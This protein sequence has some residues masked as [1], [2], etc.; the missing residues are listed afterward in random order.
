M[1]L[2]KVGTGQ[3]QEVTTQRAWSRKGAVRKVEKTGTFLGAYAVMPRSEW[4]IM[5]VP[6]DAP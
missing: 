6:L 5:Y 2:R 4:K 1:V 3:W